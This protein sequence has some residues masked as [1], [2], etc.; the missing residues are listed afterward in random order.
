MNDTRRRSRRSP[1]PP[2][3]MASVRQLQALK[4]QVNPNLSVHSA[5][6]QP[7]ACVN[8]G[9]KWYRSKVLIYKDTTGAASIVFAD[10]VKALANTTVST[11]I[12]LRIRVR[13]IKV[14]FGASA[15]GATNISGI[16]VS[17]PTA[18]YTINTTTATDNSDVN[19]IDYGTASSLPG[20]CL[21]IPQVASKP[22]ACT[23][24]NGLAL[25]D[26]SSGNGNV[27]SEVL[28]DFQM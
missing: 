16:R 11:A 7:S 18:N 4:A 24:S 21:N 13:R 12:T 15:S 27:I 8:A 3:G 22:I 6:A 9:D 20:C 14:W 5:G 1:P 19:A 26:I 17:F 28:L 25:A 10:V 2:R 23:A